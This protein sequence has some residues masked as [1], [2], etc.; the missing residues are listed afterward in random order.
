MENGGSVH[1]IYFDNIRAKEASLNRAVAY[2]YID[3]MISNADGGPLSDFTLDDLYFDGI[4]WNDTE[5]TEENADQEIRFSVPDGYP[6]DRS[7]LH[8]NEKGG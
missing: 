1:D 2:S 8:V 5:L 3:L 6:V 7:I 4:A